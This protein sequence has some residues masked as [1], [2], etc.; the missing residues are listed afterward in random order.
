[1]QGNLGKTLLNVAWMSILLGIIV[2][3]IIL[4][5]AVSFGKSLE[6]KPILADVV[7]KVSWSFIVCIGLALG[8]GATRL[9]AGMEV[10]LVG[11]VGLLAAPIAFAV[12]KSLH[13][14]IQEALFIKVY[15]GG[16]GSPFVLALIKGLEY[17]TLG[18]LL[19]WLSRKE[20]GQ[21]SAHAAAGLGVGL[22]FGALVV[23]L[24]LFDT[25]SPPTAGALISRGLNEVIFPVGCSLAL[26]SAEVLGRS[27]S[28]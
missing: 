19:G 2:E 16:A 27:K 20:W 8:R 12:A 3:A 15:Q 24:M 21:A 10:P 17:G 7:Q 18:A 6:G 23:V 22:I 28:Q 13:E 26:Y 25:T 5:V 1:M 14:G 9:M 4:V 11:A